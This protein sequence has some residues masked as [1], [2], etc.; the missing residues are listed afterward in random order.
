MPNYLTE[1]GQLVAGFSGIGKFRGRRAHELSDDERAV[2]N[3]FFTNDDSNVYAVKDEMPMELWAMLMGQYARSNLTAKERLLKL[4]RD[5]PK[6]DPSAKTLEE[7]AEVIRCEGD[8]KASLKAHLDRAGRFIESYGIDYGHA[9]LRDSA[10]VRVCFEGVSQRA[11]KFL[12]SAREG[13]YQEQSTR[14]TPFR[15]DMLAIPTEVRGTVFEARFSEIG[16]RLIDLYEKIF[17]ASF[18]YL[19]KNFDYLRA[20]ADRR[21]REETGGK[22]IGL[23]EKEWNDVIRSKAFDIARFLLPQNITTSLGMTLCLRRFQDQLTEWQSCEFEELRILG[24]AARVEAS[25]IF[26][27]LMKYGGPSEFYSKLPVRGRSLS[28]GVLGGDSCQGDYSH[29]E[30]SSKL[31]SVTPDIEDM[32]LASILFENHR[33]HTFAEILETVRKLSPEKRRQIAK[34]QFE[35]K[36]SF[37]LNPKTTEIGSFV[38]CRRYDIGAFRDLQRQRGDRQRVG[39]YSTNLGYH[40]PEE[41]SFLE[42]GL[43]EDFE[44]V[45]KEV[46]DL[47][48]DLK[49]EE[50][51]SAAQYVPVMANLIEH[52]VTMDPNQLFYQAKLRCQPAG[53]DSY[54]KIALQ[55]IEQGLEHLPAFRG[56][57]DFDSTPKYPL[58]RLVEAVNGKIRRVCNG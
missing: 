23:N 33:G 8:V 42:G 58:N 28:G 34:S 46:K 31:I 21:I 45:L 32:V 57:I 43:D 18:D 53:A 30:V 26:P 3:Y 49:N 24:M 5:V 38:F 16:R 37:E 13:A 48:D 52:V 12:E 40:M 29:H 15:M 56:L 1:G 19:K 47:H 35:G 39:P 9:S 11:T 25:K 20:E 41:I 55:E 22:C 6:K 10:V 14:A 27:F 54:R 4:L 36:K 7:I 2:I 44:K 51:H 17:S 50:M